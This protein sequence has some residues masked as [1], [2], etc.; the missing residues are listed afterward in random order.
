MKTQNKDGETDMQYNERIHTNRDVENQQYLVKQM[1]K[2][3]P[4]YIPVAKFEWGKRPFQVLKRELAVRVIQ[5]LFS[6]NGS[7]MINDWKEAQTD[8]WR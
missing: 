2:P 7:Q 6:N 3:L 8:N 4:Q 5:M 1:P